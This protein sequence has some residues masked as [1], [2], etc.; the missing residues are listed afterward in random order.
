MSRT[1]RRSKK[2]SGSSPPTRSAER[3]SANSDTRPAYRG[4][5]SESH[6]TSRTAPAAKRQ[7]LFD[8]AIW[9]GLILSTLAVYA[10]VGGFD[11]VN[12]DDPQYVFD[13]HVQ[14]GLTRDSIKWAFTAAVVGHWMPVTLLSHILD[15]QLYGLR[16]G[17][18][19]FTNVALHTLSAL[20]LFA[21]LRRATG[22]RGLSAF[23]AFVFALHPLHVGS[24]AWISERKDMLS[25]FFWLLALYGYVRY[26]ERPSLGRYLAMAAAFCL[27][28][29]SKAMIVTFPFTLFLLDV[30]PLHRAP[31]FN[32][33]WS[34]AIW[35]KTIW[36]KLPLIA[37]SAAVSSVAYWTQGSVGALEF[38]PLATRIENAFISYV[39]Y[40]GQM[41]WPV[42]LAIIYPY[43]LSIPAWKAAAAI[44]FVL[45]V[46]VLTIRAWRTRP[47]LAVGWLWYLGTLIPVIGLVQVGAQ[48]HADHFMYIPLVGL[49]IMLAWGAAD[50]AGKW[51][52]TKPAFAAAGVVFCG[53]CLLLARTEAAH[54]Q[55]SG[56]IFQ[57]AT[58]VT[59]DN[60]MAENNLGSYLIGE[61][62]YADSILHLETA[63]RIDPNYALAHYNLG[64][65]LS[66]MPGRTPDAIQQYQAAVRIDPSYVEAQN[67]LGV[68]LS[69]CA[70]AIAHFEAA[71]RAKPDY[72]T[73]SY[74]L[75]RCEMT[76]GNY[77]AAIPHFE[78]AI[79]AKADYADAHFRLATS[80]SKI[81]GRVPD[82]IK[83]YEAALRLR[84]NDGAAHASLGEL[85]ASLG[86]T[87]EAIAQLE[88]A[89]RAY[90]DAA[91]AKLL[92]RLRAGQK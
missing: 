7:R 37:L 65:S 39:V 12:F 71:V 85:L 5:S 79:R 56:T 46:S 4:E 24:V 29:L 61:Q 34:K 70:A 60:A 30:W 76:A 38:I 68:I 51:P 33:R 2:V 80:L 35:S 59:Q 62:R 45:T 83:E 36:E 27:G 28:L 78:A 32:M 63:V 19:H 90:P 31:W 44:A 10:Q 1:I 8:V 67:N 73:A 69:D 17:M 48:A 43:P 87:T 16:S 86:R 54:W 88:A 25:T 77:A 50:I 22:A 58:E 81:P 91:R 84:P 74:N 89:E 14:A 52:R 64:L 9:V 20:L 53:A 21:S 6:Y 82:A 11:F 26:A 49:S 41:F 23:V 57:R 40:I 13:P 75:A 18:H 66:K 3:D 55:N 72:A 42:R 15:G 92:D 47:Y